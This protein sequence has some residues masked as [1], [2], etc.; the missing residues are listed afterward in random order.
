MAVS[1]HLNTVD[2]CSS[3]KPLF[4]ATQKENKP[5][6]SKNLTVKPNFSKLLRSAPNCRLLNLRRQG[7]ESIEDGFAVLVLFF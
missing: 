7:P 3:I 6:I 1:L 4:A 5:Y 2:S